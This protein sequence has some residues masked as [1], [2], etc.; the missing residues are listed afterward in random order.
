MHYLIDGYNVLFSLESSSDLQLQR[1]ELTEFLTKK[2]SRLKLS[3][4]IIF[5]GSHK[6]DEESGRN[7]GSPLEIVFSPKGQT[8]D[9]YIVEH[10]EFAKNSKEITVITNDSGLKRRV[11]ALGAQVKQTAPFIRFLEK[12]THMK[13]EEKGSLEESPRELKR[14]LKI[15]E[16]RLDN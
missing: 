2:F 3:G 14:L 4:F 6:R 12:K 13:K 15:F 11:R 9:C 5:D 8:A 1:T 7:Y 10:V 16:E